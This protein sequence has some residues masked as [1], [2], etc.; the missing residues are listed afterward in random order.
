MNAPTTFQKAMDKLLGDLEFVR[1]YLDN[2]AVFS[3]SEEDRLDQIRAVLYRVEKNL[4]FKLSKGHLFQSE[5][6]FLFIS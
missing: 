2:I 4:K 5:L 3:S 1:V 6:N